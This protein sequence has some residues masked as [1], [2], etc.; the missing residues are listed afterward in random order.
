MGNNVKLLEAIF[1]TANLRPVEIRH[2][3]IERIVAAVADLGNPSTA[4]ELATH[5]YELGLKPACFTIVSC[6]DGVNKDKALKALI[7]S[8]EDYLT[9]T[10]MGYMVAGDIPMVP[11]EVEPPIMKSVPH[12]DNAIIA[13]SN[14]KW[15]LGKNALIYPH[16]NWNAHAF[17][18]LA[19]VVAHK[20][21]CPIIAVDDEVRYVQHTQS[22]QEFTKQFIASRVANHQR[23]FEKIFDIIYNPPKTI[24]VFC[25]DVDIYNDMTFEQALTEYNQSHGANPSVHFIL[26]SYEL[27]VK[28]NNVTKWYSATHDTLHFIAKFERLNRIISPK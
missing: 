5:A 27:K 26:S 4:M 18:T 21:R 22:F 20:N 28:H 1:A 10:F 7:N 15:A 8:L 11:H 17:V 3:V 12:F 19:S 23:H 25:D 13:L 9:Y 24:M 2:S 16:E 14:S 6:L